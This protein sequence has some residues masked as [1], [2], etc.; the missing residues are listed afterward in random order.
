MRFD[1][2][3]VEQLLDAALLELVKG[4]KY[5]APDCKGLAQD[6]AADLLERV[7]ADQQRDAGLRRYKLVTVVNVGSVSE[8]PDL[9]LASR[10]LWTS[11]TDA[12]ASAS[13][14]NDSLFAV[15]TV[16][17]AYFE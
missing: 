17:A 13:Y 14:A 3:R 8:S 11:N 6:L 2:H 7:K 12:F 16:Y 10:C 4:R 15:A 9:Q 1:Y 5:A